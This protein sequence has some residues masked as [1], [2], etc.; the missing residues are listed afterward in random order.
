M[1]TR[2]DLQI[3]SYIPT[4]NSHPSL[5]FHPN[6]IRGPSSYHE[7]SIQRFST[8]LPLPRPRKKSYVFWEWSCYFPIFHPGLV[9]FQDNA[10]WDASLLPFRTQIL[11]FS[12]PRHKAWSQFCNIFKEL[13]VTIISQ[14]VNIC[15]KELKDS[16]NLRGSGSPQ[17]SC[18]PCRG[19]S[20]GADKPFTPCPLKIV[21]S[22]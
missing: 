21:F 12:N 22:F 14:E 7:L 18:L 20:N 15:S 11:P 8:V 1:T 6:S 2:F 4:T 9:L 16:C 3:F 19:N 10:S 13:W 5:S 17:T